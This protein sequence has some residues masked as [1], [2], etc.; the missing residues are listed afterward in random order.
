V[1][2]EELGRVPQSVEQVTVPKQF[3]QS[4]S[5]L[6]EIEN[7]TPEQIGVAQHMQIDGSRF[8]PTIF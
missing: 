8:S 6:K 1:A 7:A 4:F 3:K 5:S 2:G